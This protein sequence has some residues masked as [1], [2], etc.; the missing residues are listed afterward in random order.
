MSKTIAGHKIRNFSVVEST[1]LKNIILTLFVLKKS[2]QCRFGSVNISKIMYSRS[3]LNLIAFIYQ[4]EVGRTILD[5]GLQNNYC[6]FFVPISLHENWSQ[7]LS[8][9]M[10]R[11]LLYLAGCSCLNRVHSDLSIFFGAITTTLSQVTITLTWSIVTVS[12]FFP[13][14][15]IIHSSLCNQKG[16]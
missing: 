8:N 2:F 7:R 3:A 15:S 13:V 9:F 12:F 10:P 14:C 4:P 6:L 16:L 11:R 5:L 1:K